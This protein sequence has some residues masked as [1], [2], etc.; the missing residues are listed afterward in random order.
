MCNHPAEALRLPSM[1]EYCLRTTTGLPGFLL[2]VARAV[3]GV[4]E[5]LGA[6]MQDRTED[7]E[8]GLRTTVALERFEHVRDASLTSDGKGIWAPLKKA[9]PYL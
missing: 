9:S 6:Q 2:L 3:A 5:Q 7:K 4:Q 8:P 1:L